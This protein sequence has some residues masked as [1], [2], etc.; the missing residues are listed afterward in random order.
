MQSASTESNVIFPGGIGPPGLITAYKE[1]RIPS[2]KPS[3]IHT[4]THTVVGA[5]QYR[6]HRAAVYLVA[7]GGN[8]SGRGQRADSNIPRNFQLLTR[9]RR[10]DAYF[11]VAQD[12][13]DVGIVRRGLQQEGIVA[14]AASGFQVY[15]IAGRRIGV[16]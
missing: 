2:A 15:A 3:R 11:A 1:V 6:H 5:R 10:P 13:Q 14:A 16:D 7:G 8:V 4:Y 12:L 9:A